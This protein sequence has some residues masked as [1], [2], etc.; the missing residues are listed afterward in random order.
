MFLHI[1]GKYTMVKLNSSLFVVI[2]LFYIL[3]TVPHCQLLGVG[4]GHRHLAPGCCWVF[5]K[6]KISYLECMFNFRV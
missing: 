2:V 3:L 4:Q 6:I 1:N 5:F